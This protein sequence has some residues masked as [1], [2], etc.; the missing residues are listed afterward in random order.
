MLSV[1]IDPILV[2]IG[3]IQIRYYGL[4]YVLS[5]FLLYYLLK[6]QRV[7]LQLKVEKLDAFILWLMIGLLIGGRMMHFL[8]NDPSMFIQRP[9]DILKIWNGGMSFFGAVI[10]G[11][12]AGFLFCKKHKLNFLKIAD[13]VSIVGTIGIIFGRLAN[14]IN[15][16]LVG[17]ITDVQWCFNFSGYTGC[18]HPYQL[19]ACLSHIILLF[20]VLYIA[21]IKDEKELKDGIVLLSFVFFYTLFRFIT[22]FFRYDP[23]F[24][25]LTSWQYISMVVFF[26]SLFSL[27]IYRK[28]E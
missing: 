18:R 9:L 20:I 28:K 21:R 3:F 8:V 14:F 13:V 4:V 25:G 10:G 5:F 26:I 16:E 27:Y 7:K 17:T 6:K 23:R 22:D 15:Q 12:L 11:G 24:F 1:N 2:E 19:Y